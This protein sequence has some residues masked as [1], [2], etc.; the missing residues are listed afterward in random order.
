MRA[1]GR[2]GE[3]TKPIKPGAVPFPLSQPILVANT[4]LLFNPKYAVSPL[5]PFKL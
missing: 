2:A 5:P 1:F 3:T 4:H